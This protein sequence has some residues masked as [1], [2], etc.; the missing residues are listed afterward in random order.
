MQ[1][2][3]R[4]NKAGCLYRLSWQDQFPFS[5]LICAAGAC[6][7]SLISAAC[8]GHAPDQNSEQEELMKPAGWNLEPCGGSK[9]MQQ[10]F[11]A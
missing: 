1:R 8:L 9:C 2:K 4:E 6:F 5:Y 11:V 7:A 3:E 10:S